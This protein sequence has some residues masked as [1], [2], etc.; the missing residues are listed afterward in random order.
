MKWLGLVFALLSTLSQASEKFEIEL[1]SGE[2]INIDVY[3]AGGDALYLYLPS[4]RGL[5]NGYVSTAQK[6]ASKNQTFWAV[7]LHSSYMIAPSRNSIDKFNIDDLLELVD[8]SKD[9]GFEKLFFIASGRGAQLALKISN[10]WQL[11]NPDSDYLKGHIF[12]SPYLIH[13]KPKLGGKA[14]Y[15]NIAKASNLPVYLIL[16]QYGTKYFRAEEIVGTLKTGGSSVFTHRL[17]GVNGGFHM[18]NEQDL[19]KISL[20]AKGDLDNT[21]LLASN[22]MLTI[23]PPEP[24]KSN[25]TE[26]K[27]AEISFSESVL[28]SYTQ[29]QSIPL[30][31]DNLAGERVSL[32]QYKD[33]VVLL[34]FWSSWCKPCVE[35][36]PSLIR[37]KN[38]LDR[39]NFQIITINVGESKQTIEDF[40]KRVKFNLP[41]LLDDSGVA[42][43]DWGVYAYPSSFL[44]DKNG[45]IRY[46]YRGALEW[47]TPGIIKTISQLL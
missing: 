36:I 46:A 35:E 12:H 30:A 34:N 45:S 22:L 3:H 1:D 11:K 40:M 9:Q 7:D 47:D 19:S 25:G 37:L 2:L 23:N 31:L 8:Y 29:K 18:R 17:K 38:K 5:G 6:M 42:V 20:Q 41:I 21:Y 32:D 27:S 43:R 39:Q 33:Q 28:K 26:K 4:E 16:P 10:K 44:L 15:M 14:E 13:G 24:L